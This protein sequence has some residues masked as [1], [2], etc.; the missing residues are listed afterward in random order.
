MDNYRE[1]IE[2]IDRAIKEAGGDMKEAYKNLG[3]K[4]PNKI[5]YE[6]CPQEIFLKK[7]PRTMREAEKF[8]RPKEFKKLIGIIDALL[9]TG[10]VFTH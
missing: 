9:V 10:H 1:E 2:K 8:L 3:F 4:Q 6:G 5:D 7:R